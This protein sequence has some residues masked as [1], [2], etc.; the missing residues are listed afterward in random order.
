MTH[1]KIKTSG[2]LVYHFK[3]TVLSSEYDTK[4]REMALNRRA[5]TTNSKPFKQAAS[6]NAQY[7][8]HSWHLNRW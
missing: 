6:T 8:D 3:Q 1:I 4:Q 2:K 5:H 7:T